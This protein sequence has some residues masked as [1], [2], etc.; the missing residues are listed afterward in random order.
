MPTQIN[1]IDDIEH[2]TTT[3][4]VE[5]DLLRPDAELIARIAADIRSETGHRLVIDLA[6][7]SFIDSEAAPILKRLGETDGFRIEGVEIFLQSMVNDV[8]RRG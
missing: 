8:E 4:R 2:G 7:L 5:G 3:L 1:Q 6:D